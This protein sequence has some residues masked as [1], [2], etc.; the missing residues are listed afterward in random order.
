L[1]VRFARKEIGLDVPRVLR[2][3][4]PIDARQSLTA[5]SVEPWK[6]AN[7]DDG[8]SVSLVRG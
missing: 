2:Y 4:F 5:H 6:T 1:K 3:Q 8:L 7:A